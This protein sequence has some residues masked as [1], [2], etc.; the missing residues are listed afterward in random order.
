MFTQVLQLSL[1]LHLPLVKVGELCTF[2][3]VVEHQLLKSQLGFVAAFYVT[4]T[5][6]GLL[7]TFSSW[8]L[9]ASKSQEATLRRTLFLPARSQAS[10]RVHD[11][12]PT[13]AR[14]VHS[15]R[16]VRTDCQTMK[17]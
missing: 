13:H 14:S 7:K 2:T 8:N 10:T 17:H 9:P 1:D 16:L 6:Q 5:D 4:L 15:P 11:A 12:V 3:L